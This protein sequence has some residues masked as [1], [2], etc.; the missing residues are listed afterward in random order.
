VLVLA[1]GVAA[2]AFLTGPSAAAVRTRH[3]LAG[4][5][6]WV[7]GR[8]G[9]RT[10]PVGGWVQANQPVLRTAA[11]ALAGLA[12]VFW[13]RPTGKVVLLL[14]GVLLV[15]LALIE[16]LGHRSPEQVS[17]PTGWR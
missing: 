14:T 2:G 17:A 9:L 8:A 16:L 11:A 12:L 13:P 3:G 7:A 5:I 4:A 10:G 15:L 1:L 6:G